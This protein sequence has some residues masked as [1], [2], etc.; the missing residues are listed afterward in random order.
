MYEDYID[1]T[2]NRDYAD[3]N[4]KNKSISSEKIHENV[5]F[6]REEHQNMKQFRQKIM[7]SK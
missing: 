1:G 5:S 7:T 4:K 2:C 3:F 6:L